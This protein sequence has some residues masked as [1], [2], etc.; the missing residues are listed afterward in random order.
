MRVFNQ[1]G[2]INKK[3]DLS[4]IETILMDLSIVKKEINKNNIN[5]LFELNGIGLPL[6]HIFISSEKLKLSEIER[7][8]IFNFLIDINGINLMIKDKEEKTP[9]HIAVIKERIY[10]VKKLLE[11]NVS[12]NLKYNKC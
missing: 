2:L 4:E 9:L 10:E 6:L 7:K 1:K 8:N 5:N 3:N 11:K 12:V